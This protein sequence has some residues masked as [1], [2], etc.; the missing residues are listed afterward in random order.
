MGVPHTRVLGSN[1]G[2]VRVVHV[3][4]RLGGGEGQGQGRV[5]VRAVTNVVRPIL[6][7]VVHPPALI[8]IFV[9]V[10]RTAIDGHGILR[11]VNKRG[12][13]DPATTVIGSL[14]PSLGISIHVFNRLMCL[15]WRG[16]LLCLPWLPVPWWGH[17][18]KKGH[19]SKAYHI[20]MVVGAKDDS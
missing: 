19:G 9:V 1:I 5:L 4:G 16:V 10:L 15:L 6:Q 7:R 18:G 2:E 8:R 12:G 17:G 11:V 20:S 3:L 14:R 13:A